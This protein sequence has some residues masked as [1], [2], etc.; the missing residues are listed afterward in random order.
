MRRILLI[1]S[2]MAVLF[3][4]AGPRGDSAGIINGV[5]IPYAEYINLLRIHTSA[6]QSN[7]LRPPDSKE[8]QVI[9]QETWSNIKANVILKSYYRKYDITVTP[10]EVIDSLSARVPAF[11]E[12]STHFTK[13]GSFDR[14][15]YLQSL[16]YDSPVNLDF[17]RKS[18][19]EY[20]LPIQKLKQKLI[21]HELLT[22]SEVKRIS[23]IATSTGSF[24]LLVFDPERMKP[25]LSD[26]EIEDFYRDNLAKYQLD[27]IYGVRYFNLPVPVGDKDLAYS[28]ALAD[29]IFIELRQG[30]GME[31]VVSER[32]Y[33]IPGLKLTD[34]GF[35]RVDTLDA[36]LLAM[37]EPL[38]DNQYS[39]PV[40]EA[41]GFTI[42]QKQQRTK[43][44]LSYRM[45]SIPIVVTQASIDAYLSQA[46]GAVNL[47]RAVGMEAAA[48]ELGTTLISH[49]RLTI[50][51]QWHEDSSILSRVHEQLLAEKKGNYLKPL[52]SAVTTS[53]VVIQ[54]SENQ[55]D[56]VRP[57]AEV[58][59]QIIAELT[60]QRKE[61]LASKRAEEWLAHNPSLKVNA[62]DPDYELVSYSQSSIHATWKGIPLDLQYLNAMQRY[63][64]KQAPQSDTLNGYSIIMIPRALRM[65][66][67]ATA[68]PEYIR[69]LFVQSLGENWFETWLEERI[70]AAKVQIFVNP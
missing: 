70:K 10:Q 41:R 52:Y 33:E 7:N 66:P 3:A 5:R 35:V 19:Q 4:C 25:V 28:S 14:E 9:F 45:L 43:S 59:Q 11:L 47:A 60:Q 16:R 68:E 23:S 37:L 13:N 21:N 39:K 69:S 22:A 57:L 48:Q 58:R 67:K 24:D 2:L 34:V 17:L 38:D 26:A 61:S 29:S 18:Y 63:Q 49:N 42:Y 44:M 64:A 6:F 8:K 12:S 54:L 32:K 50:N 30:K 40:A 36:K 27:P 51:D 20:Q 62:Q 15:I 55:I 65:N 53:W 46:N 31:R 1:I 56:R